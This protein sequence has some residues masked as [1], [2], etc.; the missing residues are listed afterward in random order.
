MSVES[1]KRKHA[2]KDV[3]KYLVGAG[4]VIVNASNG[5]IWVQEDV[6]NNE[7][8]GRRNGEIS[9][10]FET[11]KRKFLWG[12]ESHRRNVRGGLAEIVNDETLEQVG[13]HFFTMDRNLLAESIPFHHNGR[14]YLCNMAVII[15]DGPDRDFL[16]LDTEA[17]PL[18][19]MPVSE[20]LAQDHI[21]PVA[22]HAIAILERSGVIASKLEAYN[23][24]I[25]PRYPVIPPGFS[26][27]RYITG[28][29]KRQDM[30]PTR[31]RRLRV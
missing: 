2:K 17:K 11:A 16:P 1:D 28:R 6:G 12:R 23:N 29:E 24:N 31:I 5:E 18:G 14:S 15:Y 27:R 20:F 25:Q 7:E 30:T 3:E 19:W 26:L 10:A 4:V 13:E 8:T 21:R 22:K 9:T